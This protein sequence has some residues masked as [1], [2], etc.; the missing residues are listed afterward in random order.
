MSISNKPGLSLKGK[1]LLIASFSFLFFIFAFG[2]GA[3]TLDASVWGKNNW[4]D[5]ISVEQGTPLQLRWNF[6]GAL[7][8]KFE[9]NPGFPFSSS[10]TVSVPAYRSAYNMTCCM[11]E[12]IWNNCIS[13]ANDSVT[14]NVSVLPAGDQIY[15]DYNFCDNQTNCQG[16]FSSSGGYTQANAQMVYNKLWS[17]SIL[18]HSWNSSLNAEIGLLYD[19]DEKI[20]F[21]QLVS[22]DGSW[23][24]GIVYSYKDQ[25]VFLASAEGNWGDDSFLRCYPQI[26]S[27]ANR[28]VWAP[29]GRNPGGNMPTIYSQASKRSVCDLF[30]AAHPNAYDIS[31]GWRDI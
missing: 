21:V 4:Q 15:W 9:E 3:Q 8:C 5:P 20:G 17:S 27:G 18:P 13:C 16:M 26:T 23:K 28:G 2:A 19:P 30:G 29:L 10:G 22:L 25:K 12:N 11:Q 1:G 7:K 6:P 31:G 14:I 24:R